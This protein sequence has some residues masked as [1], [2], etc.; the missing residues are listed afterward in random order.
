MIVS[1]FLCFASNLP[2]LNLNLFLTSEQNNFRFSLGKFGEK[3]RNHQTITCQVLAELNEIWSCL[4]VFQGSRNLAPDS[5]V[6]ITTQES[7]ARLREPWKTLRQLHISFNSAKT[8]H[9]IVWWFLCFSPNLPKLNLKL[10]CSDVKNKFRFSSGKFEAKHRNQL[11]IICQV[12]AEL[13][14]IW[15]CLIF[16]QLY[17]ASSVRLTHLRLSS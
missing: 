12:L 7:G 5:C 3:H 4:R 8:W 14:K 17:P 1:W 9:V 2:E 6:V 10:F 16:I 13:F 11:T 15:S